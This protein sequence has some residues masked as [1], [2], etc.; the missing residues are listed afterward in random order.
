[1]F[2]NRCRNL[3]VVAGA[4]CLGLLINMHAYSLPAWGA[5]PH[6][7]AD[8]GKP[9]SQPASPEDQLRQQQ[10]AACSAF[11]AGKEDPNDFSLFSKP[12]HR[13]SVLAGALKQ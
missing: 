8:S 5:P 1:M 2:R 10:A 9:T 12:T 6:K 3:G 11:Y 13:P 4:G 7:P